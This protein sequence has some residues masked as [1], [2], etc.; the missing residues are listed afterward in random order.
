[1]TETADNEFTVTYM[2]MDDFSSFLY[3]PL[4]VASAKT[5]NELIDTLI[6]FYHSIMKDYNSSIHSQSTMFITH[7]PEPVNNI[8]KSNIKKGDKLISDSTM[9]KNKFEPVFKMMNQ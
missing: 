5:D 9:V 6:N 2:A 1:M 8:L 4:I 3:P 7:L